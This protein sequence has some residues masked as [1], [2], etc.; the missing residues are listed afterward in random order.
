VSRY[1]LSRIY[2]LDEICAFLRAVDLRLSSRSS[3]VII[4][5][6][7]AAFHQ[8]TSTTNDVD[9]REAITAEVR[10]AVEHVAAENEI[11]IP[12]NHSAVADVPWNFQDRLVRQLPELLMLEVWVLD[13][14][15]LVLSKTMRGD[16]HDEQQIL[17]IHRAV[18]LDFDVLVQRFRDEMDHVIG[19]PVRIRQQFLQL[20]DML[21]GELK[22][23]AAARSLVGSW[24]DHE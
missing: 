19:D 10:A 12:M 1:Q 5:G 7:A 24:A 8:S 18:G 9:T 22:R 14:H 4:G 2:G 21:F 11:A 3:I 15:D 20:L 16:E 23:V 13:K 17:E 6:A